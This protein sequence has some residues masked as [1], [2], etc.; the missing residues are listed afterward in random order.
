MQLDEDGGED[1]GQIDAWPLQEFYFPANYPI[2]D[3]ALFSRNFL[4]DA[5]SSPV[6]PLKSHETSRQIFKSTS[7]SRQIFTKLSR[8]L[9]IHLFLSRN[10]HT[11]LQ[12]RQLISREIF[13]SGQVNPAVQMEP[14]GQIFHICLLPASS[15]RNATRQVPVATFTAI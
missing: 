15:F 6:L 12:N 1:D 3:C 14:L 13:T 10:L 7:S 9:H 5:Q 2:D 4:S 8:N 11:P